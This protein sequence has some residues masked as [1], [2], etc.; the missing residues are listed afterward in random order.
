M[1]ALIL[2]LYTVFENRR[3]TMLKV[4]DIMTKELDFRDAP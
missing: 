2:T 4:K 3:D 1:C